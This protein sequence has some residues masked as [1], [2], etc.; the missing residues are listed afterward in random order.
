MPSEEGHLQMVN[1]KT[2]GFFLLLARLRLVGSKAS[3]LLLASCE[4][5]SST[6][7]FCED[8]GDSVGAVAFS[9][10]SRLLGRFFQTRG[11]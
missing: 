10:L 6:S 4:R 7:S 3:T 8:D 9:S 1:L 5:E 2:G 11:D